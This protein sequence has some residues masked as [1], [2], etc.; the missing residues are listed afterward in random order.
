MSDLSAAQP[1]TASPAMA[2]VPME[3]DVF[4]TLAGAEAIWRELERRA[5]LT[6]YQSFDWIAA[7]LAAGAESD[8]R[9]LV[10]VITK[11][12]HP[13][14]LLP[15]GLRKRR[16]LTE[17]H[18]LGTRQSNA[19]WLLAEPGF[20]PSKAE[21]QSIF[22]LVSQV[23]GGI[24]LLSLSNLPQSWQGHRNPLLVLDHAAAPSNLYTATIGPTPVPYID[25]RLS[26]KRRSNIN[27]GRRR[28]AEQHGEVRLV[29]ITD[30]A[31]L[32]RVHQAFLDQR[33]ARFG[34]MGID[35]M[36]AHAP[37]KELFRDLTIQGFGSEHPA[38]CLHALYAGDE[39]VATSWGLHAGTHY[40]QYIN[41]TTS[42]PAARYSLMGILVGELM[43]ALTT[44]GVTTFDMGL[45][46]FEYKTEWT[47]AEPVFNS[48]VP[49]TAKGR[50]AA[51]AKKQLGAG[52]R[53]IKQTPAL[54]RT[55][56]QVRRVLYN[57]RNKN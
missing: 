17:A 15:L 23:A 26:T 27:R 39:I 11:R 18:V 38:L 47:V 30:K 51:L 10:A 55:A 35:N 21:L 31:N 19:D 13:V 44:T 48:L 36:F 41:S 49:L 33:G 53:L 57:L 12:G 46:D 43:D 9:V 40:S 4:D 1:I 52:K 6:P 8:S 2:A 24:D 37:F 34:E 20:A 22:T 16:G 25:H 54:W 50:L 5:V 45:G 29:R 14:A 32:E 42:G 56:Q 7:L 28:L 3:V